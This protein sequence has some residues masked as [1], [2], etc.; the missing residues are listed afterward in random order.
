MAL[1]ETL[2]A[3][4][5]R[6]WR[7]RSR[8]AA[9]SHRDVDLVART[10]R[11]RIVASAI[12]LRDVEI[13][14]HAG[15]LSIAGASLL[16]PRQLGVLPTIEENEELALVSVGFAAAAIRAGLGEKFDLDDD[17]RWLAAALALERS[18]LSELPGW[19][20]RRARLAA[21]VLTTRP[22]LA[23]TRGAAALLEAVVQHDLGRSLDAIEADVP[24][25][26]R[27]DTRAAC[28]HNDGI[29]AILHRLDPLR[30][31]RLEFVPLWGRLV[32]GQGPLGSSPTRPIADAPSDVSSE[33]ASRPRTAKRRRQLEAPAAEPNP[34]THSFEKVHT[35]E[36]YT[37]GNKHADGSDELG[38]HRDALD[39]LDLDE[40]VLSN[41][42]TASV[43]RADLSLLG[44]ASARDPDDAGLRYDEWDP[45]RRRYLSR[46]CRL[47]VERLEPDPAAGASLRRRVQHEH[48]RTSWRLR[49]EL[50][51]IRSALRWS[52]RQPDGPEIDVDAVVDRQAALRA[53]H[54]G[55]ERLYARRRRRGHDVAMLLLV[56]ASL[57]TDAWVDDRRVLDTARD[58]V[59]VLL[60][61]LE[62]D[63]DEIGVAAFRSY[64]HHDC[65]FSAIKGF[66]E[67]VG[68]GL[69]RLAALRP[70][71]YTRIGPALRHGFE[72]LLRT[73]A[74]RRVVVLV[75]DGK[76]TDTDH[77]E[78]RHG[79]GDVR[80]AV[81]EG[82][83]VGVET[84]ALAI[85][86]RAAAH[87][88][89]MFG[90]RG[91]AGLAEVGDL[92]L[93]A[94]R[95]FAQLRQG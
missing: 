91:Y 37:G 73:R 3:W 44:A 82:Q 41:E 2:F 85:D 39:E 24:A 18:L 21:A 88:P 79:I 67:D 69:S 74:R 93:A 56:D 10:N 35:A 16:L 22:C 47:Y 14:F 92:A 48:R 11:L 55:G 46:H 76:P 6:R 33:H 40:V 27:A 57:S 89:A 20:A 78:G 51:R 94:V 15:P 62:P 25:E 13:R 43:Y 8:T 71:G 42:R 29:S 19:A 77:Y 53:G 84:F 60:A 30:T 17:A 26:L 59:A 70:A 80:Q 64:T 28:L 54:D 36:E 52:S 68:M 86:P 90:P 58:A 23:S 5:A 45:V 81:R 75:T 31:V 34:L 61:A 83:R 66:D 9:T 50:Q 4:F 72:V 1:D 87:L 7:S 12:A 38:E 49:D 65:R 63:I 32:P 95:L